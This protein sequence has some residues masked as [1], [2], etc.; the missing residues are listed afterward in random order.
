MTFT[1]NPMTVDGWKRPFVSQQ[2]L[3]LFLFLSQKK[4]NRTPREKAQAAAAEELRKTQA[5]IYIYIKPLLK[6]EVTTSSCALSQNTREVSGKRGGC[7]LML[8][9]PTI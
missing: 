3:S 8:I 9:F 4:Q 2:I 1:F 5:H 7:V 6:K